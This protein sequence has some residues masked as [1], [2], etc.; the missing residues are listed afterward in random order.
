MKIWR[1]VDFGV[2]VCCLCSEV[3]VQSWA[4]CEKKQSASEL[5]KSGNSSHKLTGTLRT[6]LTSTV[7]S[8]RLWMMAAYTGKM[9]VP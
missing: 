6:H 1:C 4:E 9:I 2:I 3:A 8:R 7:V 5:A